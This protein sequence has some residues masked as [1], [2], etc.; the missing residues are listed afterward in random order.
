M[1]LLILSCSLNP[2]SRSAILA[3]AAQ[4]S[5]KARDASAEIFDLR[6]HELPFCDGATVYGNPAVVDLA[7]KVEGASGILVA[8][9]VYNYDLNAAAKNV[10]ELTGQA[11]ASKTVGF[12]LAAGG[13]G[14]YMSAMPF[15]NSLMLDFRCRILPR[16]VYATG[17]A[18]AGDQLTDEELTNR[19]DELASR[20]VDATSQPQ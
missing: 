4:A 2:R 20:L 6:D 18:F 9:P 7:A 19:I 11:W 15:A 1:S 17:D 13:Q 5:L 10:V 3:K 16:F 8:A 14:S 12:L